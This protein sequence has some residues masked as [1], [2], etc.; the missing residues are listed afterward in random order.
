VPAQLRLPDSD[1]QDR[2]TAIHALL[3]QVEWIEGWS[4][5][6][7]ALREVLRLA[8]PHR[9]DAWCAERR[10]ELDGFLQHEAVRATLSRR[11]RPA[12]RLQLHREH[13]FARLVE[14]RLQR[15]TIDRLEI[16]LTDDGTPARACVIDFKTDRIEAAQAPESAE[17][18]R[19]QLEVYRDAAAE[20]LG[21]DAARIELVVLFVGPGVAV[22]LEA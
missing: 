4:P 21:I 19:G 20:L 22:R 16:E 11:D 2:G 18:Y 9:D 8:L 7:A 15:G 1:A 5:D 6:E 10:S 17:A 14:T 13:P 3:E 12:S